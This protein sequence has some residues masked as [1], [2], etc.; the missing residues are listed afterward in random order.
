MPTLGFL[1]PQQLWVGPTGARHH[2]VFRHSERVIAPT[3][4]ASWRRVVASAG[5]TDSGAALVD[6]A[7]L[8]RLRI[9][10]GSS[11]AD[12]EAVL[13]LWKSFRWERDDADDAHGTEYVLARLDGDGRLV[14]A[15]RLQRV[16][17]NV[18][19]SRLCVVEPY[20]GQGVGRKLVHRLMQ[21]AAPI[22]GAI[23][24]EAT[25]EELGFFSLLGFEAQ[26]STYV[27]EVTGDVQRHMVYSAP[28]CAPSSE[29]VGLHHTA[30]RV[31]DIE[32]SL[33]WYGI[34]GFTVY[35]KFFTPSGERACF[36]E[37]LGVRI[38]LV[39]SSTGSGLSGVQD[40]PGFLVFDVTKG[41][42]DLE[43][44]LAHLRKR[45][46]GYLSVTGEP[47]HQVIGSRLM[48]VVTVE[49]PDGLPIEFIRRE[50]HVSQSLLRRVDW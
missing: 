6:P 20:Q 5:G 42:S 48:S 35:E 15:G 24:T 17:V 32:R 13:A 11:E 14:G 2:Q 23:Y 28:V 10:R 46:G 38:E 34:V 49:D 21:E 33:A 41:C 30:I 12:R 3:P 50:G 36:V 8:P 22:E 43:S 1:T 19:L 16:G 44:F 40:W 31:S 7:G 29:C 9:A 27:N 47:A 39:E 4:V 26:G 25:R 37:G 18:E 45:N